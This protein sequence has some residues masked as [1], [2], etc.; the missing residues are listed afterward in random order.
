MCVCVRVCACVCVY[1][2]VYLSLDF[3]HNLLC[4]L[5]SPLMMYILY[6]G[7]EYHVTRSSW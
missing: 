1:V 7:G 3:I 4:V 2:S 6:M 5:L